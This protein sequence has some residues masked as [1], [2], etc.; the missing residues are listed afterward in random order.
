VDSI[1]L[2]LPEAIKYIKSTTCKNSEEVNLYE[3]IG[4][5]LCEANNFKEGIKY[6][7]KEWNGNSANSIRA[8]TCLG[9][10][11]SETNLQ[12]AISY[13]K[14]AENKFVNGTETNDE[15]KQSIYETL[16]YLS[17]KTSNIEDVI[18]Y[19]ELLEPFILNSNNKEYYIN[20]LMNWASNCANASYQDRALSIVDK[21][22][23]YINDVPDEVKIKTY[24]NI[25][26]VYLK[27]EKN[28]K[29]IEYIEKGINLAKLVIGDKCADLVSLYHNLGRAYMLKGNYSQALSNLN[30]SKLLQMELYGEVM[31]RTSDYIKECEAK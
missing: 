1:V 8:L 3:D 15:T 23:P 10:Y 12:K 7:E 28:D 2:V 21:A 20:H 13:F 5:G 31:Q 29:A 11:Y 26:F 16:I 17:Q 6:L 9:T 30:K 22:I 27:S 14:E 25:G 18:Q 4:I 19:S 24:S